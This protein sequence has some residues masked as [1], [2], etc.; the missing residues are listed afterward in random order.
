[1]NSSTI[2]VLVRSSADSAAAS[3]IEVLR[4]LVKRKLAQSF[5]DISVEQP[6]SSQARFIGSHNLVSGV[7][8]CDV[9]DRLAT[10]GTFGELRLVGLSAFGNALGEVGEKRVDFEIRRFRS[11]LVQLLGSQLRVSDFRVGLRAFG[12]EIPTLPFFAIDTNCN[13]M[14]I[15]QDRKTDGG[16]A[17]PILRDESAVI[18]HSFALHGATELASVLGLWEAMATS[19]IDDFDPLIAG[20][21]IPKVRFSQSRTRVLVGPPLPLSSIAR[22]EVDLPL[23]VNF[24]PATSSETAVRG[25]ANS[26]YPNSLVFSPDLM[27]DFTS[28][29]KSGAG[30]LFVFLG[31]MAKTFV[32][33]PKIIVKGIGNELDDSAARIHQDLVGSDGWLRIIGANSNT[34][35]AFKPDVDGVI[36]SISEISNRELVSPLG[37]KDWS[38]LV[39]GFLGTIDGDPDQRNLRLEAFANDHILLVKRSA[40]G[41]ADTTFG[42]SVRKFL[43]EVPFVSVENH[44]DENLNVES[45]QVRESAEIVDESKTEAADERT[46][47]SLSP[48]L[49]ESINLH[50]RREREK[51]QS[52]IA[53]SIGLLKEAFQSLHKVAENNISSAV[54]ATGWIGFLSLF[55]LICTCTPLREPLNFFPSSFVRDATWTGFSGIFI[56][57]ALLLLGI[58][59]KKSWQIRILITGGVV[60][61][62]VALTL[63]FFDEIREVIGVDSRQ[64]VVATILGLLTAGLLV[65]AIR[66]SSVSDLPGQ[67][68]IGRLYTVA[69]SVY[70]TAGL[71]FQQVMNRSLLG[72]SESRTRIL[73]AGAII[74]SSVLISCVTVVAAVKFREKY[75]LRRSEK[76]IEWLKSELEVSVDALRRLTA[77]QIQWAGTA[78]ALLRIASF[79]LGKMES[80]SVLDFSDLTS[81]E[82]I[83]KFDVAELQLNERGMAGLTAR[84]GRHFVE[85]GWLKRQYEKIVRKFHEQTAFRTGSHVE[86]LFERRPESDPMVF[87]LDEVLESRADS[88]RWRFGEQ[89]FNG[90]FDSTLSEIPDELSFDEIYQ[91]VLD[92]KDSYSLGGVQFGEV[93]GRD[94]LCQVLPTQIA[95]LPSNTVTRTFTGSDP[96]R[97]MQTCV[98]WPTEVAGEVPALPAGVIVNSSERVISKRFDDAVI[99]VGVRVDISEPFGIHECVGAQIESETPR[100]PKSTSNNDDF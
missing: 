83:L 95:E 8:G 12:E 7:E 70:L 98:W 67:R 89:L 39:N 9:L 91:S 99:L 59:G 19:P 66:K 73:I 87:A 15:P 41:S 3:V 24:L 81:D 48:T 46:L 26:I 69:V 51:A 68:E 57:A 31:E 100:N 74:A 28:E 37:T 92:D 76:A 20:T 96:A 6:D 56:V 21:Q 88:D 27:P 22:A 44:G 35:E 80:E 94:F 33:L 42:E 32:L 71:I 47:N 30:A 84:L 49:L 63:V 75:R 1:M 82:T 2:S 11:S 25:L 13:L 86:D 60:G 62:F 64:P 58:G 53:Q 61:T 5:F 14:V 4:D 77:A 38:N 10:F 55:F 78:S 50:F 23:P 72:Q 52:N 40:L 54:A 79:P 34:G 16:V 85:P 65:A 45:D 93:G 43:V 18:G 90:D 29:A 17:R 36:R 97:R